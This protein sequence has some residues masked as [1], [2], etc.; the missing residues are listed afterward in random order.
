MSIPYSQLI[1][2]VYFLWYCVTS[3]WLHWPM[4]VVPTWM[5]VGFFSLFKK[6]LFTWHSQINEVSQILLLFFSRSVVS[7]S[8]WPHGLQHARLPCLSLSPTVC[9]DSCPVSQWCHPT[10]SSSAR[11]PGYWVCVHLLS[12]V[13]LFGFPIFHY[14]LEFAQTHVHWVGDTIQPYFTLCCPLLHLLSIFPRIRVFSNESALCIKWPK[15]WSFNIN[16]SNEYSG[17][18]SFRIDW[19]DLLTVQGTLIYDIT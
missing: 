4:Y 2:T 7:D 17:L 5:L 12:R 16:P 3:L 18:I 15:Y 13:R 9:L 10:I 1:L 6:Y 11:N 14:L 8:L 19:F